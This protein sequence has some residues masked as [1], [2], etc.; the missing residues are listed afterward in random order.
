MT[1]RIRRLVRWILILLASGALLYL[2][3]PFRVVS[4]NTARQQTAAA[5]F[6][7]AA[8]VEQFWNNQLL[9]A[10]H[11]APQARPLL[12]ALL[13]D[14]ETALS[15]HGRRLGLGRTHYCLIAG[16]GRVLAVSPNSISLALDAD[17][18][19]PEILLETGPIFGN[20]IRDG[21][22]LVDVSQFPNSRDFNA[23]SSEINR[24]VEQFVLPA[25]RAQA[26]TGTMLRFVGCAEITDPST[27]LL[28][29]RVVPFLTEVQ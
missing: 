15:Q 25:L 24:R 4:L 1:P 19:S 21:T 11:H 6:D 26:S 22:G 2:I 10:A 13:Q 18:T 8:F 20:A 5:G 14:P 28:P 16:T 23:I 9:P 27:D 3:P 17:G 12:D 7:A 29:L